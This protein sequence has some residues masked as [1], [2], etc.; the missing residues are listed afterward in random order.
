[1]T[2]LVPA[3][4]FLLGI[5][6]EV[7]W[8]SLALIVIGSGI[9][10]AA[11][12]RRAASWIDRGE[13]APVTQSA[14]SAPPDVADAATES[15]PP[16]PAASPPIIAPAPIPSPSAAAPGTR[17]LP[18]PI[19]QAADVVHQGP[20]LLDLEAL[21]QGRL[22]AIV[23]GVALATGALFFLSLA[24]SRGWIGPEGRV[25]LGFAGAAV[26]VA[27]GGRLALVQ[28]PVRFVQERQ[29]LAHVLI[30]VGLGTALL[31]IF[32]ATRLYGLVA[33]DV[34]L[35]AALAASATVTALALRANSQLIA[36]YGLVTA[37]VAPILLGA[38]A[39]FSALVFVAVVLVGTTTLALFRSWA[40]LPPLAFLLSVGQVAG[41]L[42]TRPDPALAFSAVTAYWLL[43]VVAAGGEQWRAPVAALRLTSTSLISLNGA[44]LV[45]AGLYVLD[46][47][48]ARWRGAFLVAVALA[49]LALALRFLLWRSDRDAFGLATAGVGVAAL[50]MAIPIQ[51][52]GPIVPIAWAAEAGAIAWVWSRR[53]VPQFAATSLLLAGLSLAH[54]IAFEYPLGELAS[55]GRGGL[56]FANSNGVAVAGLLASLALAGAAIRRVDVR[57]ALTAT[58]LLILAYAIPFET[59]GLVRLTAWAVVAVA[60]IAIPARLLGPAPWRALRPEESIVPWLLPGV[61]CLAAVLA[62][63]AADGVF[64][65]A[66]RRE[67]ISALATV[68]FT[69]SRTVAI[70]VLAAA[71]WAAALFVGTASAR[72][73]AVLA[74]AT[75]LAV[76]LPTQVAPWL[77]TLG[78]LALSVALLALAGGR[79]A[80]P[81]AFAIGAGTL[82]G[83]ALVTAVSV[84]AGPERLSVGA[85]TAGLDLPAMIEAAAVYAGIAAVLAFAARLALDASVRR[86]LR[87][88]AA[89]TV[90][91]ALSVA[92]VDLVA[93]LAGRNVPLEEIQKQAQVALSVLWAGLG[94][95]AFVG[96][97]VR[98]AA[99][100]RR[101]GLGL[102]GAATVKVFLFDLASLDVAYRVLS[103]VALGVLLLGSAYLYQ[104]VRSAQDPRAH[105]RAGRA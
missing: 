79:G 89:I 76:L 8:R 84:V 96:G 30:G 90:V 100:L 75:L 67:A 46:G 45:G 35:V 49:H 33:V 29:A 68:P 5:F 10:A 102:F 85:R 13:A 23:G 71:S 72:A 99:D 69:D 58:G 86:V 98:G 19:Q 51:L 88:L 83:L 12:E 93:G 77:A 78:W 103:L 65:A 15:G 87:G 22:L 9:H 1:M 26:L 61:A 54:L 59:A 11:L 82:V 31:S 66:G 92:L 41:W 43:H 37:L 2:F 50:T 101:L 53:P 16:Q 7:D 34:G 18:A 97:L 39:T 14:S 21:L 95:I 20:S 70:G 25:I 38:P 24:F 42:F 73:A 4:L 44:F 56:P 104:R 62:V 17:A 36:G 40:W 32:A 55:T 80:A 52:G 47:D 94:G 74:T 28:G 63:V 27:A 3:V 91:F 48:L 6:L 57:S 105:G 64:A 81:A 60:A